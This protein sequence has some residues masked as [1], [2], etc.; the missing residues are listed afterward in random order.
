VR[1]QNEL[2][3]LHSELGNSAVKEHNDYATELTKLMDAAA[4]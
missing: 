4:K 2:V 1:S 3:T